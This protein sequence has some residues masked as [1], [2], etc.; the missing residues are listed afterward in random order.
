MA[1]LNRSS[2]VAL[3]FSFIFSINAIGQTD[4]SA[5]FL[6]Q[7]NEALEAKKYML[8]EKFYDKV[9]KNNPSNEQV[10]LKK[11][12]V[13]DA[14]RKTFLAKEAYEKVYALNQNNTRAIDKLS[15]IALA[16]KDFE[17]A[18]LYTKICIDRNIGEN[19]H[20]KLA[21]LYFDQEDFRQASNYLKTASEKEPKNAEVP[22]MMSQIWFELSNT[23]KGLEM[24]TIAINKDS[25]KADWHYELAGYY[26]QLKKY[27]LAY[28]H[29]TSALRL[30]MRNDNDMKMD[31]GYCLINMGKFSEGKAFLD[32]VAL[33]K[34]VDLVFLNNVAYTMFN[35]GYYDEAI[36]WWD[37]ILRLD[38]NNAKSLYMIGMSFQ[39]KGENNK[40][41]MLCDKAIA[42]DPSLATHK[43]EIS[44]GGM[45]L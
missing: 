21:K 43:K 39:R 18:V 17:K 3:G 32:E 14:M 8:A 10:W 11:A 45:G 15:D 35:K 29:Y 34:G 5:Y 37:R 28:K 30:G 2:L 24:L 9:L 31:L 6:Q 13:L 22:Y 23:P 38:K 4:S 7:A 12:D 42:M 41:M 44:M 20:S 33:K 40:G 27:D 25:T 16:Y 1:V 26:D 36:E 19:K